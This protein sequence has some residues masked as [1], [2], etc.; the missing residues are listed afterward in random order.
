MMAEVS[1]HYDEDI[2]GLCG[3]CGSEQRDS[4]MN[5]NAHFQAGKSATCQ[6]CGGVVV[7][8]NRNDREAVLAQINRQRGLA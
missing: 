4:Y 8:C 5:K 3:E 2:I 7:V 6:Y 1:G